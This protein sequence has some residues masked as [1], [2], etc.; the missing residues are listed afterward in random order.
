MT[1][2]WGCVECP[3]LARMREDLHSSAQQIAIAF[4]MIS[5]ELE[6]GCVAS[7]RK[8][9]DAMSCA[10]MRTPW[11]QSSTSIRRGSALM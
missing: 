6:S 9:C 10:S 1:M 11:S 3:P 4:E 2:Q 5:P 8:Y 7:G